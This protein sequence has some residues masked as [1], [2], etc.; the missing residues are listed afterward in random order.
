MVFSFSHRSK[1]FVVKFTTYSS[2]PERNAADHKGEMTIQYAA[3]KSNILEITSAYRTS[4]GLSFKAGLKEKKK[5]LIS[6]DAKN[7]DALDGSL[8]LVSLFKP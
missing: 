6:G 1:T 5:T 3:F 7:R 8:I 2:V 4:V